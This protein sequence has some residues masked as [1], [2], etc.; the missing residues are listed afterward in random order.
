MT[1][2]LEAP[3]EETPRESNG[4]FAR[5]VGCDHTTAS[6]LRSGT[7]MPSPTMLNK[8]CEAYGLDKSVA[9]TK[10]AE[11]RKAF[12]AWLRERVPAVAD[13]E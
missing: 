6:R 8:I 5:R 11:G 10:Y 2:A 7:R 3:V 1:T 9:L 12:S 4:S 13:P